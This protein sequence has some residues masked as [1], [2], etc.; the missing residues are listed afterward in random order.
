MSLMSNENDLQII[1]KIKKYLVVS[2]QGI[3]DKAMRSH[4]V[5]SDNLRY[6]LPILVMTF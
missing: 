5:F 6:I 2:L 4:C 3:F 1:H